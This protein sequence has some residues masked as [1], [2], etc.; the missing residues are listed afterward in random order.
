MSGVPSKNTREKMDSSRGSRFSLLEFHSWTMERMG[1]GFKTVEYRTNFVKYIDHFSL[2]KRVLLPVKPEHRNASSIK[3]SFKNT[4]HLFTCVVEGHLESPT[5]IIQFVVEC[6]SEE[7]LK[8]IKSRYS[9]NR[10]FLGWTYWPEYAW[11][12]D[13]PKDVLNKWL[14]F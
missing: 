2:D 4:K 6:R 13:I 3:S 7:D 9:L 12:T 10:T 5:A 1:N 11:V 14:E 8:I